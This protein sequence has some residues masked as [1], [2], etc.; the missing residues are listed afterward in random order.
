[1]RENKYSNIDFQKFSCFS[2]T[3][4]EFNNARTNDSLFCV[5]RHC[6]KIIFRPKKEIQKYLRI[7][8][9]N[10]FCSIECHKQ[11]NIVPR[12]DTKCTF[13]GK[14]IKVERHD[15]VK[16]ITKHFFCCHSCSASY[17]NTHR[18]KVN[19]IK[20]KVKKYVE[21]KKL[22]KNKIRVPSSKEILKNTRK[23]SVCGQN[24]CVH[25]KIC[26]S[27]L[28]VDKTNL[29]KIGFDLSLLGTVEIYRE[30]FRVKEYLESLYYDKGMSMLDIKSYFN[31]K[32]NNNVSSILNFFSIERRTLSESC[33]MAYKD[34]KIT[35]PEVKNRF[36]KSGWHI[37]WEGY[38]FFY[39]SSYELDYMKELDE[40]KISYNCEGMRIQYF[41]YELGKYRTAIPDFY[42]PDTKTIVEVKSEWTYK[43]VDRL[44]MRDKVKVYRHLGFNFQLLYEHS[45][46]DDYIIS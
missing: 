20:H 6:N 35:L 30:Y 21:Q 39:R 9:Y 28:F 17:T 32:H 22:Y 19:T 26:K 29:L 24:V 45:F 15:Y 12:I 42:L 16:S 5:C 2:F 11:H 40:S 43:E 10:I 1:M 3:Q 44:M 4:E 38:T 23:C 25:P 18:N 37:S 13:C 31:I 41:D 33:S 14:D 34:G 7:E 27:R 36:Y 8:Q 46:Y